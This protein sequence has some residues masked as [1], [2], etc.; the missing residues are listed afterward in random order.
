MNEFYASQDN[1]GR[2]G[3]IILTQHYL[4]KFDDP[5]DARRNFTYLSTSGDI[6]SSKFNNE[7]GNV[8]IIRLAEMYLIRAEANLASGTVLGNTP[9]ND[10]NFLRK[11]STP[12]KYDNVSIALI[13]KER[14]LELGMEGFAVHDL[15]RTQSSLTADLSY[16]SNKLVFPIPLSEK[17]TNTKITQ[18]PGY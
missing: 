15:K 2:G 8:I 11:R 3:D 17:D 7:F 16:N 5:N 1:G 13:Q 14:E 9:L 6:L 18:N 4:N 12:L 10:L